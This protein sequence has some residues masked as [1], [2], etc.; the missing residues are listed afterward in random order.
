M[1]KNDRKG[2]L[3]KKK[4]WLEKGGQQEKLGGEV[5]RWKVMPVLVWVTFLLTRAGG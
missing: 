4:G 1:G 2:E 5:E 3:K